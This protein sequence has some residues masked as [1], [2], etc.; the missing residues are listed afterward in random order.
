MTD[1]NL[2]AINA[3]TDDITDEFI[4]LF[5]IAINTI[6]KFMA[7][8]ILIGIMVFGLGALGKIL[9]LSQKVG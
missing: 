4:N 2:D 7:L 8:I 9:R 1:V 5:Y 6:R 3:T